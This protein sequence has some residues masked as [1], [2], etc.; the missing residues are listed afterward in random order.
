MV[1]K[2]TD[3]AH[4]IK[5]AIFGNSEKVLLHPP[6]SYLESYLKWKLMDSSASAEIKLIINLEF[7]HDIAGT[8]HC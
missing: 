2:G 3:I 1:W 8:Y 4:S 5:E 6:S 7:Q